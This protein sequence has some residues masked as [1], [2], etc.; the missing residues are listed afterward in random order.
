MALNRRD[1]IWNTAAI[2]ALAACGRSG[3]YSKLGS[4]GR[5]L[6]LGDSLTAGYGANKGDDYPAQLAQ[7]T[8]WNVI[9][10]G[11]SGDT[12]AQALA[13]LPELLEL[14]PDLVIISIGG[15]DFLRKL[16]ESET[17]AN[18]SKIIEMVQAKNIDAVLVAIPYFTAGA[19]LGSVSEHPLYE[20][21]AKQ[22]KLPLLEGAWAEVLGDKDMKSDQVHGNAKGYRFFAEEIAEFLEKQGFR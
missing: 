21:L 22:Y 12:S 5:V 14:K 16:P 6:A 15:N 8:G 17:R 1:F 7:I 4:G 2:L 11:I 19:L 20:D 10:G 3:K 9:N 13:R 18:I